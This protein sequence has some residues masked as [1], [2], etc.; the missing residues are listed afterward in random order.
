MDS[1]IKLRSL[2]DKILD[3]A[4]VKSKSKKERTKRV[5]RSKKITKKSK[6]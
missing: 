6:K 4:E 5:K 1:N 3:E 2:R